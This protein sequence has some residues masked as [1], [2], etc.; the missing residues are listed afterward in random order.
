MRSR[1]GPPEEGKAA[2]QRLRGVPQNGRDLAAPAHVPGMRPRRL[3]RLIEESPRPCAFPRHAAPA[4]SVRR[5]GRRLALV[6]YRRYVS[7]SQLDF[8]L[9][10]LRIQFH[11]PEAA[12]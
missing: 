2:H 6:L 1:C 9:L 12:N 5:K 8:D 4:H 7:L 10:R 11:N 3:L